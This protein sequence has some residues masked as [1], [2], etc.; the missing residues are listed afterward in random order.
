GKL[1]NGLKGDKPIC[2]RARL[3]K[4][5][6]A[7]LPVDDAIDHQLGLF[8]V[9]MAV[10][11][12]RLDVPD[13][14]SVVSRNVV[15]GFVNKRLV[16]SVGGRGTWWDGDIWPHMLHM[17]GNDFFD[18]LILDQRPDVKDITF[19]AA[20]KSLAFKSPRPVLLVNAG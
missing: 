13:L 20:R 14:A 6:F 9:W 8:C 19:D 3:A 2:P 15:V 17:L 5:L 12:L 16:V 11:V 1:S 10:G 7:C 4:R 18:R